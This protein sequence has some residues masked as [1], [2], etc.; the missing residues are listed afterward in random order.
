MDC[1]NDPDARRGRGI[2]TRSAGRTFSDTARIASRRAASRCGL[3]QVERILEFMP[4]PALLLDRGGRIVHANLAATS[5]LRD[6][7][8]LLEDQA[9]CLRLTAALPTESRTVFRCLAAALAADP[10]QE[11]L[12]PVRLSRPSGRASLL[13]LAAPLLPTPFA[14]DG[15]ADDPLAL[16]LIIDPEPQLRNVAAVLQAAAGLTPAESRV[17]ALVGGGF[18]G[19]QAAALLKV[20]RPTMRTHLASCFEKLGVRSQVSLARLLSGLPGMLLPTPV[21]PAGLPQRRHPIMTSVVGSRECASAR[22]VDSGRASTPGARPV[23]AM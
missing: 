1:L 9:G 8:G 17:A 18:G 14:P 7:D 21:D 6:G 19:S 16:M 5:L 23:V 20:S 3:Q 22:A 4:G 10:M 13:I 2:E 12:G 15:G 11:I